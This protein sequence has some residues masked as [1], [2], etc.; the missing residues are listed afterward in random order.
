MTQIV[1]VSDSMKQSIDFI[2]DLFSD[3]QKLGVPSIKFNKHNFITI[4]DIEVRGISIYENCLC[5]KIKRAEYFIDGIDMRNYK[6]ASKERL[7]RLI[8]G[9]KEVMSH[10]SIN[11]KQLSGKE[12]L[13]KIL[14]EG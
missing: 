11:A 8:R 3:L 9:V 1:Y 13:I 6:D 5:L 12:E 7:D 2:N 4:G 10:F 14:T